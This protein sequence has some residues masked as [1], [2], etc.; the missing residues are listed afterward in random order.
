MVTVLRVYTLYLT[1]SPGEL[2]N[3]KQLTMKRCSHLTNQALYKDN[4]KVNAT[5]S[6]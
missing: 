5:K 4:A 2:H 1:T 3:L 6:S